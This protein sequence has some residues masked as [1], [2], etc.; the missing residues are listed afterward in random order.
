MLGLPAM[1][2]AAAAR[3]KPS[4]ETHGYVV[5]VPDPNDQNLFLRSKPGFGESSERIAHGNS[6]TTSKPSAAKPLCSSSGLVRLCG[7]RDAPGSEE[8]THPRTNLLGKVRDQLHGGTQADQVKALK[9]AV[10]L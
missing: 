7:V 8:V 5:R 6:E 9:H 2:K 4:L 1:A 10:C 3:V